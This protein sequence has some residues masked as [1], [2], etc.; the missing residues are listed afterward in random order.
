VIGLARTLLDSLY[1][2][3]LSFTTMTY[4]SF[5]PVGPGRFLTMVETG[6]GVVLI[7]LLVFVFGRRAT[8]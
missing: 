2:S 8:R 3:T 4:G 1:F 7:A 6:A 5:T